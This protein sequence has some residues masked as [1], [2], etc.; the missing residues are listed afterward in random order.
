[1]YDDDNNLITK[2]SLWSNI[3]TLNTF[4]FPQF[5]ETLTVFIDSHSVLYS[6]KI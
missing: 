2:S 4:N 5:M 6:T 3:K 1:M